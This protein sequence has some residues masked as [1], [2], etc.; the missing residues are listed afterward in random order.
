MIFTFD[1]FIFQQ[2][3]LHVIIAKFI[4]TSNVCNVWYVNGCVNT[5]HIL[6][7]IFSSKKSIYFP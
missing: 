1:W 5:N 6:M 4:V 3:S 7:N 2:A